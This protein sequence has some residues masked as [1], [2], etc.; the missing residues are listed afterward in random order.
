MELQRCDRLAH[1]PAYSKPRDAVTEIPRLVREIRA[2]GE[3]LSLKT[4]RINGEDLAAIGVPRG[5]E[6]G[7]LLARLL[8]DVLDGTLP[9]EHERLLEAAKSYW[10]T[11]T[12]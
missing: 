10:K 1:A 8:E 4:M 11:E 12:P 6:M 2:A 9:N 5:R 7:A 3:C